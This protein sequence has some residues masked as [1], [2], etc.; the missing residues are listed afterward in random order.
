MFLI[1]RFSQEGNN[2]YSQEGEGKQEH[3]EVEVV[4]VPDNGWS[5]V[6]GILTCRTF[7]RI[8]NTEPHET[9]NDTDD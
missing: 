5:V 2:Y 7:E 6:G 8:L 4:E 9:R 3:A 1:N